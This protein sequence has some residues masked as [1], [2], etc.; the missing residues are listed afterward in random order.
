ML[1]IQR[2]IIDPFEHNDPD[3]Y[4]WEDIEHPETTF[5]IPSFLLELDDPIGTEYRVYRLATYGNVVSY[6]NID[7]YTVQQKPVIKAIIH[8][9]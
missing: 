2:K 7:H 6:A 8:E 1:L 3:E 5:Y 9:N 4:L